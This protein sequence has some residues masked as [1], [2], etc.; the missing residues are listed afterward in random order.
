MG[1]N[2]PTYKKNGIL[3]TIR[4]ETGL[5]NIDIAENLG[6][7]RSTISNW[8]NNGTFPAW[9]LSDI[10]F[11]LVWDWQK[12]LDELEDARNLITKLET[13]LKLLD[14]HDK[15]EDFHQDLELKQKLQILSRLF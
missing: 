2:N 7:T 1:S 12:T 15:G 6:V 11:S 5:L 4:S 8:E 14:P 9:A 13:A 10:G 3:D